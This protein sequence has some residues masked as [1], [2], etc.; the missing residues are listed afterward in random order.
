MLV[1][2]QDWEKGHVARGVGPGPGE[3]GGLH[4]TV[5]L[6]CVSIQ[7]KEWDFQAV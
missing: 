7:G 3:E 6:A 4:M 2:G 1:K 5:C